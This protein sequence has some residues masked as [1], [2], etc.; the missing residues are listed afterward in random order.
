MRVTQPVTGASGLSKA[1]PC[2]LC[3]GDHTFGHRKQLIR[4][5]KGHTSLLQLQ[6][7]DHSLIY[8]FW[9]LYWP[10]E[11]IVTSCQK[12][13]TF[14]FFFWKTTAVRSRHTIPQYTP[15]TKSDLRLLRSG[16]FFGLPSLSF[17]LSGPSP[18][19]SFR[20]LPLGF[21]VVKGGESLRDE[22]GKDA[23]FG[24]LS[25]KDRGVDR[26]RGWAHERMTEERIEWWGKKKYVEQCDMGGRNK[27]KPSDQKC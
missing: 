24:K 27:A 8:Y 17:L 20:F 7:E 23:T 22:K 19:L 12:G 21:C 1:C 16:S 5:V 10:F 4:G 3:L 9:M 25:V 14:F 26:W 13:R 11:Q 18:P 15:P 2:M 6:H